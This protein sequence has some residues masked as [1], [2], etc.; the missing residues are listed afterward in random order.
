MNWKLDDYVAFKAKY[1]YKYGSYSNEQLETEEFNLKEN[2]IET[3]YDDAIFYS[4]VVTIFG[5]FLI[6]P[7]IIKDVNTEMISGAS[8]AINIVYIIIVALLLIAVVRI[9]FGSYYKY[10]NKRYRLRLKILNT[11]KEKRLEMTQNTP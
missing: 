4:I 9:G 8:I 11:E 6:V 1:E 2:L 10:K 7:Q 3:K 5:A